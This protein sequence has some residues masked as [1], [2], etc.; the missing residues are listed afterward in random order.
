V[1]HTSVVVPVK[2]GARHLPEL[3]LA[4]S[5]EGPDE[6]LVIDS[7][8]RDTSV[9]IA[10]AAGASVIEIAAESFG[11]GRT[12][13]LAAD[14]T[15]GELILFLTQDAVP[16]EGW[17]AAHV[18]AFHLDARVGA[19]YG[20]HLPRES[21]SPMIAREL[22]EF[23]AGMSPGGDPVV[24]GSGDITF[25]SNVNAAYSRECWRELRFGDLPYA[26]DQAFGRAMLEAGWR[27][28]FHPGA[29]VVHAH[30][31]PPLEFA[32]R[33]FD[34]YRGLRDTAGHVEPARPLPVLRELRDAVRADALWMAERGVPSRERARWTARA[35]A[36]HAGRKAAA[37]AATRVPT[38]PAPLE[39][40]LSLEG[41]A[42]P[43]SAARVPATA[44]GAKYADILRVTRDGAA[45]L[46][47]PVPGMSKRARL[48]LAFVIPPFTRGSGGHSTIF[49]LLSRLEARGHTC[50]VWV[51][52]PGR[53][54]PVQAASVIRRD[55]L[56]FFQPVRAPFFTDFSAWH[57]ADVVVA[58]GWDTV[59]PAATLPGC[60]ARSYL[61][62]DH[63]PEFF[64]A[65]AERLWAEETYGLGF[66]PIAA[67]HWLRDLLAHRYGCDG[68]WFRLGVDH[69]LYHADS[70][71]RQEESVIFY[72]RNTTPRRA[73]PLGA[74]ALEELHRR[75]PELRVLTFGAQAPLALSFEH[76]AL[77]IAP[78][79]RLAEAYR[80]ASAGLC[81]SL[82]NY[83]LIP[84][85]M[86]ACGLPCVDLEGGSSEA[87]FGRDGPAL[88]ARADPVALADALD[89]VLGDPERRRQLSEAGIEHAAGASWDVAADQVEEGL[90]SALRRRES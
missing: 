18:A 73:V 60:R 70:G 19:S 62:Q 27:K 33:Y 36:H 69:A 58:T 71:A 34:E 40:R 43:R 86:M 42:G 12:R 82:T 39:R 35:V 79:A 32:R 31:Y 68:A 63:E 10:R 11:H 83:S 23:F 21:T 55:V 9:P 81:L 3:L 65:S 53:R 37:I 61:V 16:V 76:E 8:S 56:E 13:N 15:Y 89:G 48:H 17:L 47:E 59:N 24:H 52:D 7:G 6:V 38:L 45:P 20:P 75:R 77:G 41:R 72:A 51:Q 44:G 74:L 28:V 67:S 30:D 57:G 2:D 29:A 87:M 25:L 64:P 85:E 54:R 49:E 78:P 84:Q 46:D 1:T 26:E 50:T 90:R 22:E 5:R 66:Y 88:L 4:L 14:S 80:R